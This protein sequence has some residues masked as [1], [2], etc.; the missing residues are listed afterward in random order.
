MYSVQSVAV[1][2][3]QKRGRKEYKKYGPS[4]TKRILPNSTKASKR[5]Q[6]LLRV[7]VLMQLGGQCESCGI[8]D[9]RVLHIDHIKNN[10]AQERREVGRHHSMLKRVLSNPFDYQI[11][12]ANCHEIKH[13]QNME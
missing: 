13:T 12:C 2:P 3:I 7:R 4:K 11:L 6:H 10:G 8:K 1:T 5:S 9:M